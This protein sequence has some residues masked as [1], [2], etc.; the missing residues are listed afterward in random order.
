M[1]GVPSRVSPKVGLLRNSNSVPPYWD[2]GAI[3]SVAP[4]GLAVI[5]TGAKVV[6]R[7]CARTAARPRQPRQARAKVIFFM[8]IW[9]ESTKTNQPTGR[10]AGGLALMR[11]GIQRTAGG[12]RASNSAQAA[13][14]GCSTRPMIKRLQTSRMARASRGSPALTSAWLA[15]SN[16]RQFELSSCSPNSASR[17][18]PGVAG[19]A[20]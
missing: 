3:R 8:E 12:P 4:S 9:I 13:G 17:A 2:T 19:S 11:R 20:R 18:A 1:P 7:V 15:W 6:P 14:S 5:V 10:P 16:K